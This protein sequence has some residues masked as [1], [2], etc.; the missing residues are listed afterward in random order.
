MYPMKKPNLSG[1][2]PLILGGLLLTIAI[3]P[4]YY[5]YSQYRTAQRKLTDPN[6]AVNEEVKSVMNKVGRLIVLPPGETPTIATISDFEKLK[7]KPFFSNAKNG[8]KLLI[9]SNAKKAILYDPG[10]DKIVDVGPVNLPQPTLTQTSTPSGS[11]APTVSKTLKIVLYNGT[12]TIGLTNTFEKNYKDKMPNTEVVDKD[13][14][15]NN[16]YDKTIIIDLT[17]SHKEDIA[18]LSKSIGAD[19]SSLPAGEVKPQNAD[20]LIILGKDKSK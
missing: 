3:A 20:I 12:Q 16:N 19:V 2:M 17:S 8:D 9:F 4:S 10:A 18:K 15:K 7:D 13:N 11:I 1:K 14:S 5:F 6:F